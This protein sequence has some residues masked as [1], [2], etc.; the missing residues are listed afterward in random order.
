[1]KAVSVFNSTF[2]PLKSDPPIMDV[3]PEESLGPIEPP[4]PSPQYR[5]NY[6]VF[7]TQ[8]REAWNDWGDPFSF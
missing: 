8:R 3:E 6:T 2:I 4:Y 5:R 7:L 1:V